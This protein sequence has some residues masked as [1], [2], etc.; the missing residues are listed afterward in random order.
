MHVAAILARQDFLL[1]LTRG[2]MMFGAPSHRL[3]AQ[4]QATA[5]V[6][7]LNCQMVYIPGVMLVSFGDNATHTSETKVSPSRVLNKTAADRQHLL[8]L[9]SS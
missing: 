4:M 5:R 3:E 6:L 1:K 2:L 7:E 8:A 9:S